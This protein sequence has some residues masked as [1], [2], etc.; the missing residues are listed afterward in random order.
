MKQRKTWSTIA[1]GCFVVAV[2]LPVVSRFLPKPAEEIEAVVEQYLL[3]R[4]G[5]LVIMC[6]LLFLGLLIMCKYLRCPHCDAIALRKIE[7]CGNCGKHF[8]DPV[9]KVSEEVEAAK[10]PAQPEIAEASE[11]SEP[12]QEQA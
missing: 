7:I 8:D 9:E 12:V 6:V 2:I 10:E 3:F 1:I 4:V 5:L 11:T